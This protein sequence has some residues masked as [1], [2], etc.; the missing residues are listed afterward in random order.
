MVDFDE[1]TGKSPRWNPEKLD[2][3]CLRQNRLGG[4]RSKE[5]DRKSE[6]VVRS[7]YQTFEWDRNNSDRNF[8]NVVRDVH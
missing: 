1:S 3:T 8:N 5:G 2:T 6:L 7:T 4:S